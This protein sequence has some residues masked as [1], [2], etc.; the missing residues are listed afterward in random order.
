ML[1]EMGLGRREAWVTLIKSLA[2][3]WMGWETFTYGTSRRKTCLALH[4]GR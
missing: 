1:G 4:F 2:P 3:T